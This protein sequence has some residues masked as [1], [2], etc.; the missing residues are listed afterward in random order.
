MWPLIRA[1]EIVSR[2][3]ETDFAPL[4]IVRKLHEVRTHVASQLLVVAQLHAVATNERR[5]RGTRS[6]NEAA[7]GMLQPFCFHARYLLEQ[8]PFGT[9]RHTGVGSDLSC[10]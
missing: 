8:I 1:S 5:I 3:L 9:C 4:V 6:V 10:I 7:A 2:N